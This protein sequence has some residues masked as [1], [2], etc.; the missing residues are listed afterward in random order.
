[1]W[2]TSTRAVSL[3]LRTQIVV[4]FNAMERIDQIIV[5]YYS[6]PV[7]GAR[8]WRWL[9]SVQSS[10]LVNCQPLHYSH[11]TILV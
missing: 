10:P 2:N 1:M 4:R 3:L 9:A 6:V 8:A 5:N 7:E 11:I